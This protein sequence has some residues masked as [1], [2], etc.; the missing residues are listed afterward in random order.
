MAGRVLESN[1]N[2]GVTE[3]VFNRHLTERLR[4]QKQANDI[5]AKLKA[6]SKVAEDD[7]VSIKAMDMALK[8]SAEDPNEVIRRENDIRQYLVFMRSKVGEQMTLIPEVPDTSKMSDTQRE[9]KWEDE[10]FQAGLLAKN[11]DTCPHQ[12][13]SPGFQAWMR[14]YEQGQERNLSGIKAPDG[15]PVT[16]AAKDDAP[17]LDIP[18]GGKGG[19][20]GRPPK[21]KPAED[22]KPEE[23]A[24][25][26]PPAPPKSKGSPPPLDDDADW[27]NADPN[28]PA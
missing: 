24:P 23:A 22:A 3:D 21:S 13:E 20:R 7:G 8:L 2:G 12:P 18:K 6:A 14:G 16:E 27:E 28:K 26:A 4:L 10:G 11:R 25:P 5:K 15:R 19:R 9:Q 1:D 17:K